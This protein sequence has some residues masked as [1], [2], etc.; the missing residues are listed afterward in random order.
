MTIF[1]ID[2]DAIERAAKQVQADEEAAHLLSFCLKQAIKFQGDVDALTKD[3][4]NLKKFI[5]GC[6]KTVDQKLKDKNIS[7]SSKSQLQD[8]RKAFDDLWRNLDAL[9][10]K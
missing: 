10:I 4:K 3:A 9:G 6:W 8:I 2:T 7:G 5:S 1:K